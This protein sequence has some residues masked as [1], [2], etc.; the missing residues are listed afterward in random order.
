MDDAGASLDTRTAPQPPPPRLRKIELVVNPLSGGVGPAA[1]GEAEAI[2]RE[3]GFHVR[4]RAVEPRLMRQELGAAVASGPDLL[5]VLAGDG[6]ARTAASLCG[7]HGPLLA[8]LAGGTMN[9]LPHALYGPGDWRTA[10]R[11]TLSAGV[12]R[13]VSGGEVDEHRFHVA[14]ILGP[15]AL[16]AEAREAARIGRF[17]LAWRKAGNAWRR[18][19]QHRLRFALDGAAPGVAEAL[20]LMCPLTSRGMSANELALEAAVLHPK[21]P[22]EAVR[23]G[24]HALL[25]EIIGD[26]RKD[27][28]VEI[29]RCRTGVA[30]A[31]RAHVHAVLDGEP[32]RLHRRVE[33]RFVPVA[34]RALATPFRTP[35]PEVAS[36]ILPR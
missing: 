30:W 25:R 22:A 8:P 28:S 15:P 33:F 2:I 19:F 23:L 5:V 11:E 4:V 17:A 35:A 13:P 3:F 24:L 7:A 32:V 27:P 18:T 34:F 20:A 36:A 9:M 10:L 31:D 6:T 29:T 12:V 16:W 1:A 26:W 21:S 14:A